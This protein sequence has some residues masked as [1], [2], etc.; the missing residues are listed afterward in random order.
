MIYYALMAAYINQRLSAIAEGPRDALLSVELL[1]NCT[2]IAF[3]KACSGV[4]GRKLFQTFSE[5]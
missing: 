4:E 5:Y 3:E 2:K 1:H